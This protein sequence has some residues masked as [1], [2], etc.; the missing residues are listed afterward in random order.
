LLLSGKTEAQQHPSLTQFMFNK[1]IFN[2]ASVGEGDENCAS[3]FYRSQWVGF[4]GAPVTMGANFN[5]PKLTASMG[6]GLT[7]YSDNLGKYRRIQ[8]EG[9]YSYSILL[10][11]QSRLIFGL[12]AGVLN[13][14]FSDL[15]WVSPD[16]NA[17]ADPSIVS[18]TN[19]SW[20]PNFGVGFTYMADK[21][22]LGASV[23]NLLEQNNQLDEVKI[24]QKRQYYF[25][26]GYNIRIN[27]TFNLMPNILLSTD[28]SSVNLDVNLNTVI[29]KDIIVGLSYKTSQSASILLGYNILDM[30]DVYYSYDF[31]FNKVA[32][33]E[34]GNG[35]HE[36]LLRY[37]F[38]GKERVEK[39]KKNRN[40][41]FL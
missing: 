39:S 26:G 23:L 20:S 13:L 1:S 37:C 19:S 18:S 40:V 9:N 29:N 32:S 10:N 34:Y 8:M 27:S 28:L 31:G 41:R 5:M 14:S 16:G 24:L 21:L 6:A 4:D 3:V 36:L 15:N 35:S 25:T 22:Y 33:Y 17:G 2:P 7:V 11:N 30:V 38:K 12:R